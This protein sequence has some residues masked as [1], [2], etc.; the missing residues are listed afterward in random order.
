MCAR[1]ERWGTNVLDAETLAS[2]GMAA[3]HSLISAT[4]VFGRDGAP[5]PT[6]FT[7]AGPPAAAAKVASGSSSV[8]ARVRRPRSTRRS[9]THVS[10]AAKARIGA[11]TIEYW[12]WK[13]Q[14][15]GDDDQ[16]RSRNVGSATSSTGE[17]SGR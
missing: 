15:F 8:V 14:K 9:R 11:G 10:I 2:A 17:A 3:M 1:C 4:R 6:G 7:A 16:N 13:D 5:S 12:K